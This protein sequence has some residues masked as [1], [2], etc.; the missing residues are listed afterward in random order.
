MVFCSN[1]LNT[2]LGVIETK[3]SALNSIQRLRKKT[4]P[5][6]LAVHASTKR[7]HK[8]NLTQYL[9]LRVEANILHVLTVAYNSV[10]RNISPSRLT[11]ERIKR[12]FVVSYY[13]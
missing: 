10:I 9:A 3:I 7:P 8:K 1:H 5:K 12:K 13:N 6:F 4:L 2:K 11:T